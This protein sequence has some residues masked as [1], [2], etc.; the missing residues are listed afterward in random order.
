MGGAK[1]FVSTDGGATFSASPA[2]LPPGSSM[3][4]PV[5][6]F[7]GDVWLVAPDG[8][9]RSTNAAANFAHV[10]ETS[11]ASA[12][13]FGMAADGADYPAVYLIGTVAGVSGVLRSNDAGESWQRIDDD[14]HRFGW[15]GHV[16]G[17][18]RI[19][20]RVYLGTGGRGVIY[21]GLR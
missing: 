12:V 1:I 17:D 19:Y 3:L 16:T 14:E 21:G 20:G 4:R 11:A 9:Y 15:L 8:L 6:G 2:L 7:E 10:P 18:P 5:P 13:G